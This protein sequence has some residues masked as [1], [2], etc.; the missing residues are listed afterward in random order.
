M[1][2][3]A[4]ASCAAVT[5]ALAMV[6]ATAAPSPSFCAIVNVANAVSEMSASD[7]RDVLLGNR[8]EW[9]N[10]RHIT[11]VQHDSGPVAAEV[12]KSILGMS[13]GEY[14]RH[15]F[16]LEFQG[17]GAI[18]LK[19]MASDEAV[20]DFVSNA[21]GAVGFV[22]SSALGLPVCQTR[23]RVLTILQAPAKGSL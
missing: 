18:S 13:V 7:L 23:I 19:A 2:L 14:T 10:S 20:C 22:P 4:R 1:G 6:C 21:P 15:L 8:R 5:I 3:T 11:V 16:Q 17:K 12:V 9:P